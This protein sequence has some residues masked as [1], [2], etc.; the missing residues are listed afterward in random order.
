MGGG[1]EGK[2]GQPLGA[3]CGLL[4]SCSEFSREVGRWCPVT[5]GGW[6]GLSPHFWAWAIEFV[7]YSEIHLYSFPRAFEPAGWENRSVSS[8]Q[9][10]K[11]CVDLSY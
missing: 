7:Q 5:E 11:F 4:D 3:H 2:G 6:S 8:L 9:T 1:N 10:G